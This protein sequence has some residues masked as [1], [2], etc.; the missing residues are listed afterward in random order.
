MGQSE[1]RICPN[2]TGTV[3]PPSK[4]RGG[5]LSMPNF[6]EDSDLL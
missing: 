3:S 2:K 6:R 4:Y 5:G 1:Y